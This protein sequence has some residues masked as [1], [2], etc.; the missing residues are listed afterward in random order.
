MLLL[1]ETN[2]LFFAVPLLVGVSLVYA[3]TRHEDFKSIFA[4]AASFGIWTALFMVAFGSVLEL[5]GYF[6]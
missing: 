2:R 5:L 3:A 4:H 6:Q 1:A